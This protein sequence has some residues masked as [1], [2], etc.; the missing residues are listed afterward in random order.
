MD[1]RTEGELVSETGYRFTRLMLTPH[2]LSVL[3]SDLDLVFITGPP[4]TGKTV[5][6]YLTA[7]DWHRGGFSVHIVSTNRRSLAASHS[8]FRQLQQPSTDIA[9]KQG[10][11]LHEFDLW[12]EQQPDVERAFSTLMQAADAYGGLNLI[13][14]EAWVGKYVCFF[15]KLCRL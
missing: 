8:L 10:I 6:L 14:D 2:Q 4:G 1:L 13:M 12:R 3:A 7:L 15:I 9:A 11:F 5:M